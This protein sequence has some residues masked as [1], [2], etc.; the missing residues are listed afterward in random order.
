MTGQKYLGY[1]MV[2]IFT[3]VY[4]NYIQIK[5][6]DTPI[7]TADMLTENDVNGRVATYA[8]GRVDDLIMSTNGDK[9]LEASYWGQYPSYLPGA[10]GTASNNFKEG[11]F[12][13]LYLY[14]TG[15]YR[16]VNISVT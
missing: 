3:N 1:R 10:S 15:H 14:Q 12:W 2:Q 7:G 9:L 16:A 13:G 11:N 5:Q 4:T 8:N 6:N